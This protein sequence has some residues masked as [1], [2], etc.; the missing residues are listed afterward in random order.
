[1]RQIRILVFY[2]AFVFIG[3]ALIAP[4]AYKLVP[5]SAPFYR[6]V[7]RSLLFLA[8]AGL[9]PFVRGIGIHTWRDLGFESPRKNWKNLGAGFFLGFCSLALLA[10][11]AIFSGQRGMDSRLTEKILVTNLAIAILT[12]IAVGTLEEILFRGALFG[13]LRKAIAWPAALVASSAIYAIV[14]FF[15][16][17]ETPVSVNWL[18]GFVTLGSMLRGFADVKMLFPD[19]FN[20]LIA[21]SILALAYQ[22]SGTLFFSIG[23]HAGWIFWLKSYGLLTTRM[24]RSNLAFWGGGKMIDGWLATIVLAILFVGLIFQFQEKKGV[25]DAAH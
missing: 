19:F 16:K 17:P 20:L 22:R 4:W 9:W 14:H 24:T 12:A 3:G 23:L 5:T 10:A 18:S 21:G 6:Y 11:L 25:R 1:V 8:L 15:A 7:H 2:L 13:M